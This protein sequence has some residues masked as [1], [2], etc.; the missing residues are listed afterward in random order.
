MNNVKS[1]VHGYIISNSSRSVNSNKSNNNDN[2][3]SNNKY[4][5]Y[6]ST[7]GFSED[8]LT[9][10]FGLSLELFT[11]QYQGCTDPI[12]DILTVAGWNST[13][14]GTGTTRDWSFCSRNEPCSDRQGDCDS[15]DECIQDF[16]CGND[17]CRDFWGQAD[18]AADC[19]I[20]GEHCENGENVAQTC[21]SEVKLV[22]GTGPH[23]GNIFVGGK[24]VCDDL[25]GANNTLVVCRFGQSQ[26]HC[27]FE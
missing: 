21:L 24:P 15:D 25:H 17:N 11:S 2:N 12:I 1:F 5:N 13:S 27:L 14:A 9:E 20:A 3:S 8:S 23:E 26:I 10:I 6:F 7:R 22:G 4:D 16:L 18:P 19:C